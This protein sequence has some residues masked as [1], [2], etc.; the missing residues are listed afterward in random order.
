MLCFLL[1]LLGTVLPILC[2]IKWWEWEHPCLVP[3][4]RQN[5]FSFLLFSMMLAVSWLCMK[6]LCWGVYPLCWFFFVLNTWWIL[7]NYFSTSIEMTI[8]ILFFSML[9]WCITLPDF[10]CW[11]QY[12]HPRKKSHWLWC[13]KLLMYCWILFANM[14]LRILAS[15]LIRHT[16]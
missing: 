9:M 16:C 7:S 4:I 5:T 2:W 11:N 8:W 3:D 10:A 13:M 1:C 6:V 14:L 12:L 15:M